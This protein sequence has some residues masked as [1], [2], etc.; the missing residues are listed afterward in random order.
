MFA[1][2]RFVFWVDGYY[3]VVWVFGFD[4]FWVDSLD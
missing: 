3:F 1:D 2:C 4:C